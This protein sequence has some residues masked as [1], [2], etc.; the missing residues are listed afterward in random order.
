VISVKKII[1]SLVLLQFV[2]GC[3][4]VKKAVEMDIPLE[5]QKTLL[6][7]YQ[8]RTAWTRLIL[9]DLKQR[10]VV[11]RDVQITIVGLDFHWNGSVTVMTSKR[12]KIVYGLN[13]ERPLTAESIERKLDE[14][15]WFNSPMLRQVAYIR[16][17]GKKTARAIRN[18]EVFIGMTGE[19]ALES[20]GVPTDLNVNE[21]GG[22]KE[23]QWVYKWG[24]QNKYIYIIDNKVS[25]WED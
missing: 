12:K 5:Q 7:K 2:L 20:W 18:H 24:K 21:I 10:G 6:D 3:S 13:L 22:K 1:I 8:D 25:K 17:W 23:E 9:D 19:A 15:F 14:V 11:Q 4:F 16:E